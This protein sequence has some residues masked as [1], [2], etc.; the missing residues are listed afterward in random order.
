MYVQPRR[1]RFPSPLGM[2]PQPPVS[3]RRHLRL[4]V[5]PPSWSQP[6]VR[7]IVY[8]LMQFL[9]RQLNWALNDTCGSAMY[10]LPPGHFTESII[11]KQEGYWLLICSVQR[12][13]IL[14][15]ARSALSSFAWTV[16]KS[17]LLSLSKI[18]ISFIHPPPMSMPAGCHRYPASPRQQ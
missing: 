1:S 17:D 2:C 14:I 13:C 7:N 5:V 3:H 8:L 10:R 12:L 9:R 18:L 16:L 15:L 6:R 11:S 4:L